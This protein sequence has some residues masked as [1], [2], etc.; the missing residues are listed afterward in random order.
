MDESATI[1]KENYH[2][3]IKSGIWEQANEEN[4]ALIP[5]I[6]A[7]RPFERDLVNLFDDH[8]LVQCNQFSN[9]KGRFFYLFLCNCPELITSINPTEMHEV[10]KYTKHHQPF[11]FEMATKL[12]A[13]DSTKTRTRKRVD[14]EKLTAFL[15]EILTKKIIW[16]F[17]I[18]RRI[19]IHPQQQ[20]SESTP[21]K[22]DIHGWQAIQTIE[23]CELS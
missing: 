2:W 4:D 22:R 20:L 7:A 3:R 5:N 11:L 17:Q 9:K 15:N 23:T 8:A 14:H 13:A 6:D 12:V 1:R 19:I 18:D 16:Q 21:G 10:L